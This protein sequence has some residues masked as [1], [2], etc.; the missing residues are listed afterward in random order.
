MIAH[1]YSLFVILDPF[2]TAKVRN[3]LQSIKHI[4]YPK[5]LISTYKHLYKEKS[6][7][8]SGKDTRRWVARSLGRWVA[9]ENQKGEIKRDYNYLYYYILYKL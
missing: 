5:A 4:S 9:N 6:Q 8:Y 7:P 2:D 1:K 3:I